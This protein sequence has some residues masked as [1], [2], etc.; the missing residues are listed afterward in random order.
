VE[1]V[2]VLEL[3]DSPVVSETIVYADKAV[4]AAQMVLRGDFAPA[5]IAK[6]A[7]EATKATE[8][9]ERAAYL[10]KGRREQLARLRSH[11]EVHARQAAQR[12][13]ESEFRKHEEELRRRR[14]MQDS[15]ESAVHRLTVQWPALQEA[16]GSVVAA[17]SAVDAARQK[18]SRGRLS[19]ANEAVRA[20]IE[21]V[22]E[23]AAVNMTADAAAG[24]TGGGRALP[25][26]E[27]VSTETTYVMRDSH[28]IS[29]Q[30][31][32]AVPSAM[33]SPKSAAPK[34]EWM[35]DYVKNASDYMGRTT[36]AFEAMTANMHFLTQGLLEVS[37]AMS[38]QNQVRT[39]HISRCI[40]ARVVTS[41]RIHRSCRCKQTFL[42]G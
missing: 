2:K 33:E 26:D 4:Q 27:P 8:E 17:E 25:K 9:A 5:V 15:L 37:S 35:T 22:D 34:P 39:I 11:R 16:R 23:A 1:L 6:E 32:D 13:S 12:R 36:T 24:G 3:A 29:Y 7:A 41:S 10:E 40:P 31:S 42:Q 14:E 18:L 38:K 30:D 21:R 20:A 19:A 28:Y